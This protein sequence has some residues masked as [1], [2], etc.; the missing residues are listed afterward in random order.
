MLRPRTQVAASPA[1]S[2]V[3]RPAVA[4]AVSLIG[5]PMI[6]LI[7]RPAVRVM[8]VIVAVFATPDVVS[9]I[10][11]HLVVAADSIAVAIT[12]SLVVHRSIIEPV[13]ITA[14]FAASDT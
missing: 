1:D 8:A 12:K 2:H 13:S 11:H 7:A 3:A 14:R 5:P 6:R 4:P 10:S 9:F